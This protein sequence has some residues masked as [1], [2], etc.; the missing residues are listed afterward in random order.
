MPKFFSCLLLSAVLADDSVRARTAWPE[1]P[2][3]FVVTFAAGG[4]SNSWR[5]SSPNR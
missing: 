5:A 2:A 4:T 3:A 1:K